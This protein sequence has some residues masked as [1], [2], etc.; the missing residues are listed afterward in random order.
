MTVSL[1]PAQ[2]LDAGALG[3]MIT[4]AVGSRPWKP[5]LH[6]A[7][8]D[9]GHVGRMI[10]R[11]WVTVACDP[12]G[13]R[14]GFLARDGDYVHALFTAEAARGTG[15]G[16]KLITQAKGA[17][18]RLELWTFEAN[19]AAQRFYERNGFVPVERTDGQGNEER[20][21]DVR[22]VWEKPAPA[23]AEGSPDQSK[24]TQP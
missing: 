1:R 2:P 18:S 17:S 16:R 12:E 9:I 4:Q 8:E 21:P 22:Y 7:A 6:S 5:R 24:E 11:G 14:L 3:A 15:V 20:L 23:P 19:V 13:Q 10:D